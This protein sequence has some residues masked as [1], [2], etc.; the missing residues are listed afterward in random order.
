MEQVPSTAGCRRCRE[1][2][3]AGDLTGRRFGSPAAAGFRL[4]PPRR[5]TVRV[6]TLDGWRT[7]RSRQFAPQEPGGHRRSRASTAWD[8]TGGPR[9][10]ASPQTDLAV[11]L[12]RKS[13]LRGP[14]A[15]HGFDRLVGSHERWGQRSS[16]VGRSLRDAARCKRFDRSRL[17]IRRPEAACSWPWNAVAAVM[18]ARIKPT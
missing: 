11:D 10:R 1:C 4:L 16:L 3:R 7:D 15:S 13:I 6:Q 2:D 9:S 14:R 5:P 12:D 18:L 8:Q 17:P